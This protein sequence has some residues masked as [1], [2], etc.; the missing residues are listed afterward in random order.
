MVIE[1]GCHALLTTEQYVNIIKNIITTIRTLRTKNPLFKVLRGE[2]I[3]SS[4]QRVAIVA[5]QW[6]TP[7]LTHHTRGLEFLHLLG[8]R[9]AAR[10]RGGDRGGEDERV[11]PEREPFAPDVQSGPNK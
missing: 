4:C 3:T 10:G 1:C 11:N 8:R 7:L 9:D 2:S 5:P 6:P